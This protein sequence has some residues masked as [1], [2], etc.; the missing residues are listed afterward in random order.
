MK[1]RAIT[2]TPQKRVPIPAQIRHWRKGD[3]SPRTLCRRSWRWTLG[4]LCRHR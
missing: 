1:T 4:S 3:L 2:V